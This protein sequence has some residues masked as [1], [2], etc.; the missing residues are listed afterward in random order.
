MD[1]YLT[2]GSASAS[3]LTP[4][5]TTPPPTTTPSTSA[6]SPLALAGGDDGVQAHVHLVTHLYVL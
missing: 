1:K 5:S 6:T 2:C 3:E 4:R